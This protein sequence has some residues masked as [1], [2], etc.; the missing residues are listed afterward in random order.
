M[1]A[2]Q[3]M[4]TIKE[5]FRSRPIEFWPES[6]RKAWISASRPSQ[7]L[8]RGGAGSHLKPIT[9]SDLER[10][11]GYFLDCLNRQGLL[12]PNK[13]AGGTRHAGERQHLF[14]GTDRARRLGD[15]SK[16]NL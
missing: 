9:L 3:R 12:D 2:A 7:R 6:D 5:K 14:G 1:L 8:K 10:R 16:I 4:E 13:T 15:G 11:Y